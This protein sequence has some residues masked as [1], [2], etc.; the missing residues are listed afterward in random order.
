MTNAGYQRYNN[1][2][3]SFTTSQ[4]VIVEKL[5]NG[6]TAIN[7]GDVIAEIN[8]IRI[9]PSATPAT[10]VGDSLSVGGNAGEI[11]KGQIILK[12]V[13]PTAGVA[14]RVVIVQKYLIKDQEDSK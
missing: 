3:Q 12:F 1:T 10:V 8:G 5:C 11:Y 2:I 4:D 9:F 7:Y 14:P 6:F 13:Q